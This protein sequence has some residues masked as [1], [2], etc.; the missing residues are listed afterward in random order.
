MKSFPF[1]PLGLVALVLFTAC[2][3]GPQEEDLAN[4]TG[5]WEI[6]QVV[7][8]DGTEKKYQISTTIEYLQWDG[9]EGFRK[10]MQPTLEGTYLTSD[11]A[12]PMQVLWRD[13]RL[14]LKFDGSSQSWEE[15]VKKLQPAKL[16][17]LHSNGLRYE[18]KKYEPLTIEKDSV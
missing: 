2:T 13:R 5:Y 17:L 15:E 3:G 14:F 6:E 1:R 11:D 16:I 12:L 8:P 9:R 4:L 10:K 7:F 18:Y